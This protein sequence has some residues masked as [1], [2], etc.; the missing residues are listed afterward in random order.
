MRLPLFFVCAFLAAVIST[1]GPAAAA[2]TYEAYELED[3]AEPIALYPDLLLQAMLPAATFPDQIIDAALLIKDNADAE[4]IK[5]QKWDDSVKAVASYP[6]ILKMMNENLQWTTEIGQAFLNQHREL[7]DAIQRLRGKAQ[8]LGNLQSNETQK[9]TQT[10][11]S[12]GSTGL[13]L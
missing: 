2:K 1:P 8:A 10:T 7:L 6:G 12:S 13:P 9:V 11:S 5:S 4:K 3:L